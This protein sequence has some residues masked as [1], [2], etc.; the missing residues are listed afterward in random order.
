[1]AN[2]Q[3]TKHLIDTDAPDYGDATVTELLGSRQHKYLMVNVI[4]RRKRRL[5]PFDP[6]GGERAQT[7]IH[8]PHS[9]TDIILKEIDEGLL[10][11]KRKQG[12]KVLVNLIDEEE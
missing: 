10:T 5:N 1:M 7:E 12:S 2:A 9:Y 11:L 8:G 6:E 3:Q 4:A